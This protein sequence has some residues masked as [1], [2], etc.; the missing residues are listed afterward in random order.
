METTA[1]SAGI[2]EL[3]VSALADAPSA[4]L[5]KQMVQLAKLL[6]VPCDQF[7]VESVSRQAFE[8]RMLVTPSPMFVPAQ[9]SYMRMAFREGGE[10][11]FGA[12]HSG[13]LSD[14][15]RRF[16]R[17][18]FNPEGLSGNKLLVQNLKA[19]HIVAELAFLG[20]LRRI[21]SAGGG[22][23]ALA[24]S[25]AVSFLRY[26]LLRWVD[27][28]AEYSASQSKDFYA[29]VFAAIARWVQLDAA[30]STEVAALAE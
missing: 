4:T 21:E 18:S 16:E 10:W 20:H 6:E 24:A 17:A 27:T 14:V 7:D 15:V 8:D 23:G 29:L 26:H 12:A 22:Q 1:N 30:E 11:K 28:L 2:Y 25:H 19:D 13:C 3:F 5:V 9:E